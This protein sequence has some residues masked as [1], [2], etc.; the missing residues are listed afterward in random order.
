M[1][2]SVVVHIDGIVTPGEMKRQKVISKC[3]V[4]PVHQQ[5]TF[6][7]VVW[8]GL[9][10]HGKKPITY[11][12]IKDNAGNSKVKPIFVYFP[13]LPGVC[14]VVNSGDEKTFHPHSV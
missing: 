1:T 4:D 12:G 10:W 13:F 14:T 9:K 6:I 11:K 7:V 2:N 5:L 8:I 3:L